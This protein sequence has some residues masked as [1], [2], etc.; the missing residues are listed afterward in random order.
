MTKEQQRQVSKVLLEGLY[1]TNSPISMLECV[2]KD[3]FKNTKDPLKKIS[4]TQNFQNNK[5]ALVCY[6]AIGN[7]VK[8]VLHPF[9]FSIDKDTQ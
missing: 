4:I 5:Q 9:I 6:V 7:E 2:W 8:N 1:D 3:Q